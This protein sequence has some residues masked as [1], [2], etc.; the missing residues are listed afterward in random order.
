MSEEKLPPEFQ[1]A[2]RQSTEQI[3]PFN[4]HLGMKVTLVERGRL[5]MEIPFREEFIG[6]VARP[7][8][9][10]GVIS[11]LLDACGG[12]VVFTVIELGSRISTVDLRVDYLAPGRKEQLVAQAEVVRSGNRV[13]VV[14]MRAFHPSDEETAVAE[15]RAVY[16]VRRPD[17]A[18]EGGP[19]TP[20]R[21][22]IPR[23]GKPA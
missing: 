15:G 22:T 7:A 6:D 4:R 13:V 18:P 5:R 2:L 9:H 20:G 19:S 14:K 10:G 23:S 1:E 21:G 17:A 3:V 12:A 11:S 8:L 16:N